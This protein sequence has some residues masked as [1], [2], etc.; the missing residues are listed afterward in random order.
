MNDSHKSAAILPAALSFLL[1]KRVEKNP[2]IDLLGLESLELILIF[3]NR[4]KLNFCSQEKALLCV[5]VE[6]LGI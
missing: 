5:E 1:D 2:L 6:D 3:I 4:R